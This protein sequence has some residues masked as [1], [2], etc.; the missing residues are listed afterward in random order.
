[1]ALGPSL[2][3]P[4]ASWP[5]AQGPGRLSGLV[6][7]RPCGLAGAV[8]GWSGM[9]A[10]GVA[11][12]LLPPRLCHRPLWDGLCRLQPPVARLRCWSPVCV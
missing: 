4:T 5:G 3:R 12:V 2:S 7:L 1:M 10:P 6:S 8:E 9:V 11:C